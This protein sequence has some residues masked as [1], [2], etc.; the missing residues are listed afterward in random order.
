MPSEH[1]EHATPEPAPALPRRRFLLL[2]PALATLMPV[3]ALAALGRWQS[4]HPEP[5]PGIDASRV[6]TARDLAD[7]PDV[8][9]LFDRI[10]EIPHIADGIR[11]YCG[12][13]QLDD[14]RSLLSCYEGVGMARWCEICQGQAR[15]AHNR[16]KEGQSLAQIRRAID[17]RYGRGE[18]ASSAP[19]TNCHGE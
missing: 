19:S 9:S 16:W 18:T 3:P 1:P 5:R 8:I 17:A 12:C 13:A 2:L 10:R 11:C 4:G 7:A 14:Y 15:L 6:L